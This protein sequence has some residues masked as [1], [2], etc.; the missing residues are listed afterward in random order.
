MNNYREKFT[1]AI[2]K[3]PDPDFFYSTIE[4]IRVVK[5]FK[6]VTNVIAST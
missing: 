5:H 4:I 3:K 6:E 1:Q 2:H